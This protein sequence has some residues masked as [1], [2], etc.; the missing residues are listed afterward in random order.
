MVIMPARYGYARR[1][2]SVSNEWAMLLLAAEELALLRGERVN[3]VWRRLRVEGDEAMMRERRT[4]NRGGAGKS[5]TP[6][7]ATT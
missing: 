6:I 7:N 1:M 4:L 3:R 5:T 2:M